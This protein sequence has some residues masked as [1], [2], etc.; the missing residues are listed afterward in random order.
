MMWLTG[1]EAKLKKWEAVPTYREQ[2][3]ARK[4]K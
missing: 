2:A 3:L 1:E 4:N